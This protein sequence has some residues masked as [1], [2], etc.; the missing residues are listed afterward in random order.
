MGG[1]AGSAHPEQLARPATQ[2]PRTLLPSQSCC[3]AV[4]PPGR[5]QR[6]VKRLDRAGDSSFL[7]SSPPARGKEK[8]DSVKNAG[9]TLQQMCPETRQNSRVVWVGE[10]SRG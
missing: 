5:T 2:A 4:I 9:Q 6:E 1:R 10:G 7:P 3:T 8:Q